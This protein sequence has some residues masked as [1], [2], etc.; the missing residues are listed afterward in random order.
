MSIVA[1]RRSQM[2]LFSSPD[3]VQC[4]RVR[5]VLEEKGIGNADVIDIRDGEDCEDLLELNP[6]CSLPTLLDRDLVLYEPRIV[7]EYLDERFPHPPLMPVDPVSRAR[8]R[9][10]LHRIEQDMY[11]LIPDL[12]EGTPA[13]KRKARKALTEN[14]VAGAEVFAAKPF[15]I[16]DEFSIVDCSLAPILWRLDKYNIDL[17]KQA[18]PVLKYAKK[19]FARPAFDRS[20]SELEEEHRAD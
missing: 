15:F 10:A 7:M 9:L 3:C 6:H 2:T 4:H 5:L 14:L 8:F 18:A 20:L 1:N 11:S 19:M 17:P 16:S 13:Q 12:E